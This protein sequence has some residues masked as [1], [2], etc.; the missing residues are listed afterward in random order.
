MGLTDILAG[1]TDILAGLTAPVVGF[2]QKRAE[3]KAAADAQRLEIDSALQ[4]K[5]LDQIQKAED[6][7]QA[8][9]LAAL[10]NTSWKDEYWTIVL[11]IPFLGCFVPHLAPFVLLGFQTLKQTPM[12]YQYLLGT[13]VLAGFGLKMTDKVWKWW[14]SP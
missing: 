11:S 3:I 1:L 12:F 13:A 4:Q 10:A 9:N 5:K 14:A 8:W 6:Y 2:F 7:E